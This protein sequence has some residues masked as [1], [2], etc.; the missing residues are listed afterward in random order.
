MNIFET[1][2]EQEI[3]SGKKVLLK[4]D[5]ILFHEGETC[6]NIGIVL[7]GEIEIVSYTSYG[8]EIVFNT[9]KSGGLFG[10]NLLF[11]SEP[12]Y[13]G[14]V[15]AKVDSL[16]LLLNEQIF[17]KILQNNPFF[18]KNYLKMQSNFTKELN[19]K[20]KLLSIESAEERI[21]FYVGERQPLKLKSVS[22]LSREIGLARETVSRKL[23]N[24]IKN[25]KIV[26]HNDVLYLGK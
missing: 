20:I 6:Q 21:M 12:F 11:S 2:N 5:E 17:T 18:L 16:I 19:G 23:N 14:N 3:N 10:Q 1:L 15:I 7:N 22:A 13:R 4:K 25:K 9:I 26:E 24:L 8:S